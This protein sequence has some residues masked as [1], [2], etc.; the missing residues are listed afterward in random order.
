LAAGPAGRNTAAAYFVQG[1]QVL[2]PLILAPY[3]AR[4]LGAEAFGA[5]LFAQAAA[6]V[7]AIFIEFGCS[8]TGA[9]ELAI[10]RD[11]PAAARR[12]VSSI[13]GLK[14]GVAVAM[15]APAAAGLWIGIFRDQPLLLLFTWSTAV[16]QGLTPFWFFQAHAR[17]P[18]QA[19]YELLGRLATLLLII[20]LVK[21]PQHAWGVLAAQ[22][23][24]LAVATGAGH[25][26]MYRRQPFVL[27][28]P[29]AWARGRKSFAMLLFTLSQTIIVAANPFVLGL[30]TTSTSAVAYFGAAERIVRSI[31]A[32]FAPAAVVL[33][34]HLT[35]LHRH[36]AP[37]AARLV[38]RILWIALA[39]ALLMSALLFFTA[40]PIVAVFL[41]KGYEPV[42]PLLRLFAVVPP[43][44]AVSLVLGTLWLLPRGVDRPFTMTLLIAALLDVTL[45]AGLGRIGST[46][47]PVIAVGIVEFFLV[48]ATLS[49]VWLTSRRS[50]LHNAITP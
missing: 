45:V 49:V 14:I 28:V 30:V 8:Y 33:Y 16:M 44:A 7:L 26:T 35:R 39:V 48:L 47:G 18:T 27:S 12:I 46:A 9:R 36:D 24:G 4:V 20:G 41:G 10:H 29:A 2:L 42:V 43:L 37:A 15:L 38:R 31:F 3:L 34:P 23:L 32:I 5:V 25:L 50:P 21:Q 6:I 11:D 17:I 1:A 40:E 22:T 13:V 19:R